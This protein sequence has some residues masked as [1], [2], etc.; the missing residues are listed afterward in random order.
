M[1]IG[2]TCRVLSEASGRTWSLVMNRR[3]PLCAS[4]LVWLGT[5]GCA[6]LDPRSR[7]AEI[8][9][10]AH[11]ALNPPSTS[12]PMDGPMTAPIDPVP[13]FAGPQPVDVFI[14]RALAENRTVQA[15]Y[16]NVQSLKHRI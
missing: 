3:W 9:Q 13:D 14:R 5:A 16:H 8:V 2:L 4:A 10:T 7:H 6:Q 15:A 11:T 1:R 12:I